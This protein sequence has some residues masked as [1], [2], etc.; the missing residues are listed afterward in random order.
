MKL[1]RERGAVEMLCFYYI[2]NEVDDHTSGCD[3]RETKNR[4][5]AHLGPGGDYTRGCAPILGQVRLV[6]L[7]CHG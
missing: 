7:E 6:Q 5:H 3:Q 1:N 4:V 2:A